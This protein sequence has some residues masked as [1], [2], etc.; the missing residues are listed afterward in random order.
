M[1]RYTNV[2]ID[3]C[4]EDESALD[5]SAVDES[6]VSRTFISSPMHQIRIISKWI[7]Y[8]NERTRFIGRVKEVIGGINGK[9]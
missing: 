1:F 9:R 5:E 2:L 8:E 4:F 6:V 3:Q 7:K